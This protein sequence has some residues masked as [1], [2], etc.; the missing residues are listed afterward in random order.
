MKHLIILL[1]VLL[2]SS[3]SC[4]IYAQGKVTR[5]KTETSQSS[6]PIPKQQMPKET[7][8]FLN[9]HEWVDL[10]LP[11]GT[12]WATMN[13]GATR[14]TDEGNYYAW[15][16]TSIPSIIVENY[17][18]T[19]YPNYSRECCRLYGRSM[20]NISNSSY[21]VARTKWGEGWMLPEKKD[22]VELE[23]YCTLDVAKISGIDGY[24]IT[25]PNGNSIFFPCT[26]VRSCSLRTLKGSID[27]Y[28]CY[29]IGSEY[30]K[31]MG[32]LLHLDRMQI[33]TSSAHDKNVG[34]AVRAICRNN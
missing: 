22:I 30:S 7:K 29:W 9:G 1:S 2:M 10:G 6:H 21:D 19:R 34:Y 11:S 18:G 27:T 26:D 25:G 3:Y 14:P 5:K 32:E 4:E 20:G 33:G 24:K 31:E 23:K 28:S 8:G 13:I 12:K 15:G 17:D 16:E